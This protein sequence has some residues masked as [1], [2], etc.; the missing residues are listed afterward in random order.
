MAP[1]RRINGDDLVALFCIA[2]HLG[3]HVRFVGDEEMTRMGFVI[4]KGYRT[5]KW[6]KISMRG[7]HD[8]G[9]HYRSPFGIRCMHI[10]YRAV[11]QYLP[12]LFC[13]VIKV[14]T[15]AAD[16]ISTIMLSMGM[17]L[18]LLPYQAQSLNDDARTMTS[19][20]P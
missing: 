6:V 7:F 10:Q 18:L 12:K 19:R 11:R 4:R 14:S 16:P 15:C 2:K 20:K 9:S 3:K 5:P 17:E 13:D 8:V 1:V